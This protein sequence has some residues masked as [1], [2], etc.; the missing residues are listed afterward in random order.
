M[1][2]FKIDPYTQ[3]YEVSGGRFALTEEIGNNIYLSLMIR[4][5]TWPFAPSFGSRLHLLQREKALER[6]EKVAK[7]YCEEALKWIIDKGRAGKIDV[8]TEL[9]KENMRMKCLIEAEQKG[10]KVAYEH[11]V[12]VR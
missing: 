9:D 11:F 6:M 1:K 7:E 5:G 4:K 12:E 8:A 10:Q 3:D 2:D